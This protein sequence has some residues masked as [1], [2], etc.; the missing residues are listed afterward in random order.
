MDD[1][2]WIPSSRFL[3]IK[4]SKS[5]LHFGHS[6]PLR[7]QANLYHKLGA[8]HRARKTERMYEGMFKLGLFWDV[9]RKN[10]VAEVANCIK[11]LVCTSEHPTWVIPSKGS[12]YIQ[13]ANCRFTEALLVLLGSHSENGSTSTNN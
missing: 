2:G 8:A 13:C 12:I 3:L 9:L 11:L 7:C 1:F 6:E 10:V 5:N 4:R